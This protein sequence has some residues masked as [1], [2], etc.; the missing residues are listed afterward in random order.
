MIERYRK[1]KITEIWG[2]DG[3]GNYPHWLEGERPQITFKPAK[4][5]VKFYTIAA[6]LDEIEKIKAVQKV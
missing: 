1:Q 4:P 6:V 5:V 2:A 3:E